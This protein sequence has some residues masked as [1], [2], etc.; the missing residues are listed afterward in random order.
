MPATWKQG[1]QTTP[2]I[3]TE[4]AGTGPAPKTNA[5]ATNPAG[6]AQ[7]QPQSDDNVLDGTEATTPENSGA[8]G[9]GPGGT[10]RDLG[11]ADAGGCT[12][13][14]GRTNSGTTAVFLFVIAGAIVASRRRLQGEA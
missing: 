6:E 7:S 1:L 9:G 4:T 12:V 11:E 2:G 8:P 5:P 10:M 13:V 14:H 3:P